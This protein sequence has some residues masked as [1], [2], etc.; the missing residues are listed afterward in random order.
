[1]RSSGGHCGGRWRGRAKDLGDGDQH[2]GECQEETG[3]RRRGPC[4]WSWLHVPQILTSRAMIGPLAHVTLRRRWLS[5]CGKHRT[6]RGLAL[7]VTGATSGRRVPLA[8]RRPQEEQKQT[9]GFSA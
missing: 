1:M 8:E 4:L 7:A 6:S 5:R 2:D 3:G 9:E